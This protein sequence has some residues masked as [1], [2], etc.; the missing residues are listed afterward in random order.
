[1]Q[2]RTLQ[3]LGQQKTW[4][5]PDTWSKL[6]MRPYLG[7]II[8]TYGRL[9]CCEAS[10]WT[11]ACETSMCTCM[12]LCDCIF[13]PAWCIHRSFSVSRTS[14]CVTVGWQL[15]S[16]N[17]CIWVCACVCLIFCL[18]V[19]IYI[20]CVKGTQAQPSH[21]RL[22]VCMA[23]LCQPTGGSIFIH[24]PCQPWL[25]KS[26]LSAKTP[27]A[28]GDSQQELV[29]IYRNNSASYLLTDKCFLSAVE[30]WKWITNRAELHT[31]NKW[32]CGCS[33]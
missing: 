14:G 19:H 30:S 24:P 4:P 5:S 15:L 25:P 27:P 22:P 12:W 13:M 21:P 32:G 16:V 7:V 29:A 31:R 1:M 17:V 2:R 8:N 26:R 20:M 11:G 6:Y 33:W 28:A 23:E 18:S 10:W 9:K 3:N